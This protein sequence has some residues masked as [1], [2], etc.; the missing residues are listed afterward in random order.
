MYLDLRVKYLFEF[1]FQLKVL[2]LP[3]MTITSDF[4]SVNMQDLP[5]FWQCFNKMIKEKG[6]KIHFGL[7][8]ILNQTEGIKRIKKKKKKTQ[9]QQINVKKNQKTPPK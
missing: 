5:I 4:V 6:Y 7:S 2:P 3:K 8:T 9:E 1:I